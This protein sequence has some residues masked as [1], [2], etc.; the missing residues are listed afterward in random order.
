MGG[1]VAGFIAK[2]PNDN[3]REI[4]VALHHASRPCQNAGQPQRVAGW[5]NGVVLQPR[6]ESMGLKIRLVYQID[7]VLTAQLVPAVDTRK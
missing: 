3:A 4:F 2:R 6:V 5:H 7:A 1:A